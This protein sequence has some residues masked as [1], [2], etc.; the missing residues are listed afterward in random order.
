MNTVDRAVHTALPTYIGQSNIYCTT[1]ESGK[2]QI[3]IFRCLRNV[4][5]PDGRH[6]LDFCCNS[7]KHNVFKIGVLFR[8]PWQ[9][10]MTIAELIA[11]NVPYKIV[12]IIE[13]WY[14]NRVEELKLIGDSK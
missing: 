13:D 6:F 10:K 2:Y 3:K 1:R 8:D 4:K 7:E 14:W 5:H 11:E 12:G 9:T